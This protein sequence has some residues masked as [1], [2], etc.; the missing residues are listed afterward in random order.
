MCRRRVS[1]PYC[2]HMK[3]VVNKKGRVT[4]PKPLRASLGNGQGAVLDFTEEHG[5]LVARRVAKQDPISA[6]VGL[7][8]R[9]SVDRALDELR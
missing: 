1:E 7:L 8:P 6:L 5:K 9:M 4:I 3:R 2:S